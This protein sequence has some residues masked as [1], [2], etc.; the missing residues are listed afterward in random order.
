MKGVHGDED[1]S[2][3]KT[4]GSIL[5]GFPLDSV[6]LES[7]ARCLEVVEREHQEPFHRKVVMILLDILG[8][9]PSQAQFSVVDY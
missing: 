7:Q 3:P 5:L 2:A 1:L 8:F 6:E 9:T 4:P